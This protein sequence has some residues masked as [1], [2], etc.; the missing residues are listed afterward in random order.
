MLRLSKPQSHKD[1]NGKL[2]ACE[3]FKCDF[4]PECTCHKQYHDKYPKM[5]QKQI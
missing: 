1:R 2:K 3:L 5:N 4:S